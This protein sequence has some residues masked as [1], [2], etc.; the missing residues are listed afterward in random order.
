[1]IVMTMHMLAYVRSS[2]QRPFILDPSL[3]KCSLSICTLPVSSAGR[4]HGL[5]TNHIL[6]NRQFAYTLTYVT[7]PKGPLGRTVS[8][9]CLLFDSEAFCRGSV[10]NKGMRDARLS[11]ISSQGVKVCWSCVGKLSGRW[12]RGGDR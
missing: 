6:L 8:S 4:R 5:L 3:I 11:F 9:F 12:I 10:L 7:C 1:M 2:I